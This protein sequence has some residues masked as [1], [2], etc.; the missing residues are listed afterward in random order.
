MLCKKAKSSLRWLKWAAGSLTPLAWAPS[1][2]EM[3]EPVQSC[4]QTGAILKDFTFQHQCRVSARQTSLTGR[5]NCR[6]AAVAL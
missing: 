1:S 4:V 3:G 5:E 2:Y 6:V